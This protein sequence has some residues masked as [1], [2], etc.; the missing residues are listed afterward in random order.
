MGDWLS[1]LYQLFVFYR[2][3]LQ[4]HTA[5]ALKMAMDTE[6]IFEISFDSMGMKLTWLE[7]D[8]MGL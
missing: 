2:W 8:S 6:S 1:A 7:V 5:L 4:S 3:E